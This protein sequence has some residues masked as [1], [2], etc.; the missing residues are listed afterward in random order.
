[1]RCE[2][3]DCVVPDSIAREKALGRDDTTA[4]VTESYQSSLLFYV[5]V[6]WAASGMVL[7][8]HEWWQPSQPVS[9]AIG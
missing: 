2:D 1:M 4:D 3:V 6:A 8:L 7:W 9:Q 5:G